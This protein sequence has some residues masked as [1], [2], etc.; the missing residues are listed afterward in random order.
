[1]K[2]NVNSSWGKTYLKYSPGPG[3]KK[4][5]IFVCVW[6]YMHLESLSNN[7][8]LVLCKVERKKK[9]SLEKNP[10]NANLT[11]LIEF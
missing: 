6:L 9:P 2:A 7:S 1:M 5:K 11:K 4:N 8:S 3:T 10:A